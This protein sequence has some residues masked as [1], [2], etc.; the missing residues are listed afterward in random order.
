MIAQPKPLDKMTLAELLDLY[1]RTVWS[2]AQ[3]DP[4][5]R[6][7]RE[8]EAE[9]KIIESE[10]RRRDQLAWLPAQPQINREPDGEILFA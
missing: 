10:A 5:Q 7:Y 8:I 1:G 9:R 2:Q 3:C 4:G 6:R